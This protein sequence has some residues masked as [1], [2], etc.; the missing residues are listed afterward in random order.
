MQGFFLT[1]I[2]NFGKI[3]G[4][5]LLLLLVAKAGLT[6]YRISTKVWLPSWRFIFSLINWQVEALKIFGLAVV[7]A[8]IALLLSF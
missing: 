8:L 6:F 2:F 4:L 3:F 1:F 5:L 7:S